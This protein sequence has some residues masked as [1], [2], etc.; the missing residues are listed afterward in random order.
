MSRA[1]SIVI[2]DRFSDRA[3]VIQRTAIFHL[4]IG[5]PAVNRQE[6]AL[7][8]HRIVRK[9]VPAVRLNSRNSSGTG[10]LNRILRLL[11][12]MAYVGYS[13]RRYILYRSGSPAAA[14]TDLLTLVLASGS[15]LYWI[16]IQI[17]AACLHQPDSFAGSSGF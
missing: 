1:D 2:H 8:R 10:A 14:R 5:I 6:T 3:Y 7:V 4:S 13:R 12:G 9:A 15:L 17:H 16:V 11:M